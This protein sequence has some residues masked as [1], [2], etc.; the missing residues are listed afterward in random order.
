MTSNCERIEQIISSQLSEMEFKKKNYQRWR[1]IAVAA[2]LSFGNQL[3]WGCT[4]MDQERGRIAE[5][6]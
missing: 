5:H 6:C 4:C 3:N 1:R 2:W